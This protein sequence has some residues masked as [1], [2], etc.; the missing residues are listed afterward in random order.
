MA[1]PQLGFGTATLGREVGEDD[2]LRLLDAAFELGIRHFD[3]AEAYG[4]G[5]ARAYR[6][7]K[8]GI[9]DQREQTGILHSSEI[10]LGRWLRANGVRAQL[11]IATKTLNAGRLRESLAGSLDRLGLASVDAYYLHSMPA[12]PLDPPLH[13]SLEE[14]RRSK[15][16]GWI[17]GYGL[18]NC[19]AAHLLGAVDVTYC[20]N[21]FNLIQAEASRES[22]RHCVQHGVRFVAYSPLAAGFLTGKY[23]AR[24]GHVPPGT[25]FDVIPGH[26]DV[27][28]REESYQALERLEAEA[29]RTGRPK[30]M[31]ALEWVLAHA[32][33]SIVLVGAT[34]REHLE[35]A[36]AARAHAAERGS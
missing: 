35:N 18:S 20:Q 13:Q 16:R 19:T 28:F 33:I 34:R 11:E 7:T 24:G 1:I 5:N 32:E 27:Y 3:T 9:G 14:L 25:R 26:Q 31:L 23:G 4:G 12:G 30:H 15:S 22:L 36:A 10:L 21:P 2:S 17:A 29:V 8:L 6:E